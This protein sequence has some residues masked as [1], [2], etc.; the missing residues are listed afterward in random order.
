M[1]VYSSKKEMQRLVTRSRNRDLRSVLVIALLYDH[2][3][4][5]ASH[6]LPRGR[7]CSK[8]LFW[9]LVIVT[10]SRLHE[11]YKTHNC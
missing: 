5:K 8:Q 3:H 1:S 2:A 6:V 10:W 4:R 11:T 9:V 7:A